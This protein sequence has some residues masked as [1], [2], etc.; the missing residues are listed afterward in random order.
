MYRAV[1][2]IS[3][4]PQ[5]R[6]QGWKVFLTKNIK[7]LLRIISKSII[8]DCPEIFL[9]LLD[10]RSDLLCVY[11]QAVHAKWKYKIWSLLKMLIDLFLTVSV[12]TSVWAEWDFFVWWGFLN[13]WDDVAINEYMCSYSKKQWKLASHTNK[14]LCRSVHKWMTYSSLNCCCSS[15][16]ILL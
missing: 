16:G 10:I 15:C 8:F 5:R 9:R 4:L 11:F 14:I 13:R 3:Q 1:L 7:R 6:F 12:S 2:W